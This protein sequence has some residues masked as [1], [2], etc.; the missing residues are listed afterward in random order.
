MR[1]LHDRP[2]RQLLRRSN[3]SG[4]FVVGKYRFST[5]MACE[6]GCIYCDGRAERY[7]VDG[8]FDRD[9]VV[10]S[11][12]P[13]LLS[14]ELQKIRER[15][16]VTIGSGI[17]DAYQPAESELGLTRRCLEVL[18]GFPFPVTIMTKSDLIVRDLD[19]LGRIASGPGCLVIASL[20]FTDD[21]LRSV[22]EPGAATVESRLSML[23]ACREAGC[24]IGVLAMPLLPGISDSPDQ[25]RRLYQRL[26]PLAPDFIMPAGL[27]LRPGRQ[28]ERFLAHLAIHRPDLLEMYRGIYRENRQ[29]GDTTPAYRG[30]LTQRI[31]TVT[32]CKK[33]PFLVPHGWYRHRLH[34]YD[35]LQ[36]LLSHMDEL[37]QIRGIDTSRLRDARRRYLNWLDPQKRWHNRHR[38]SSYA[39]LDRE[40]KRAVADGEMAEVLSNRRLS[41]FVTQIVVDDAELD[42]RTLTLEPGSNGDPSR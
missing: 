4:N 33:T 23:E 2:V 16:I 13:E 20:T 24:R 30:G 27:T 10:R 41:E 29:S 25:L 15:G 39:D 6:H 14:R 32:A 26:Q 31:R 42:Y 3:L 38:S 8:V 17:S 22:W 11:N 34:Q 37:Y 7:H 36:V 40:L 21:E 12:A 18:A 1:T 5:Y 9:I 28:K 19:L 35:A